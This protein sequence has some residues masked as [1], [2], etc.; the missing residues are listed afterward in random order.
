MRLLHGRSLRLDERTRI[1]I[2]IVVIHRF[3]VGG[4]R[5]I[6][7]ALGLF[8]HELEFFGKQRCLD[9]HPAAVHRAGDAARLL[10]GGAG[11]MEMDANSTRCWA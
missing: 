3:A 5:R 2:E 4:D 10:D 8:E 1:G 9:I 7:P 11:G 6:L